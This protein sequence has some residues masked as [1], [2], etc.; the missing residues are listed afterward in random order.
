MTRLEENGIVLNEVVKRVE[1]EPTATYEK[2][3]TFQLGAI[4]T[5]LADISKSLAVI[6]DAMNEGES[7]ET[8][9]GGRVEY[10]KDEIEHLAF[11]QYDYKLM[12]DRE[13]VLEILNA[14]LSDM[15]GENNG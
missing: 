5:M 15:R 3:V 7:N 14:H 11:R 13:E 10:I 1:L 8:N 4:V 2:A 9:V 12:L 6:A